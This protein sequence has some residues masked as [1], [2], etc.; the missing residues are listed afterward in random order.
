LRLRLASRLYESAQLFLKARA[1]E[2]RLN[3]SEPFA[4]QL[5]SN[6][7]HRGRCAGPRNLECPL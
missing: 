2:V 1:V 4:D 7:M 3:M 5:L 6:V